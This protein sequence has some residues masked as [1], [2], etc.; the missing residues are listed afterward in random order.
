ML[1]KL[2]AIKQKFEDLQKQMNDPDVMSDMKR[3]IKLNK[4]YKEIQPVVAAYEHYRNILSNLDHAREIAYNE[5]DEEFRQ[6]AK[7]ELEK[8]T[9]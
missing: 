3:Y 7:E 9:A 5:K 1:D 2:A 8:L 4:D 6:L